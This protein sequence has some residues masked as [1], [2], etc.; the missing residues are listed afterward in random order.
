MAIHLPIGPLKSWS[1]HRDANPVPT[2]P[3]ADDVTTAPSGPVPKDSPRLSLKYQYSLTNSSPFA[4][5]RGSKRSQNSRFIQ[6][7]AHQPHTLCSGLCIYKIYYRM[8]IVMI[9]ECLIMFYLNI[10]V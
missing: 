10:S 9:N 2:S 6:L 3:L 4:S 1:L 5:I 7:S 8:I